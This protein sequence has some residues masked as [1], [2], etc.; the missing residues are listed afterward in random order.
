MVFLGSWLALPCG[1]ALAATQRG[2]PDEWGE[3]V[4]PHSQSEKIGGNVESMRRN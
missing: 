2:T 1:E 3:V 4:D